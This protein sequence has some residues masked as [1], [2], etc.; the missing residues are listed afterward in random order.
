MAQS[1]PEIIEDANEIVREVDAPSQQLTCLLDAH[2]ADGDRELAPAAEGLVG[3]CE[4][5]SRDDE[6]RVGWKRCDDVADDVGIPHVIDRDQAALAPD[7]LTEI[8]SR[9]ADGS[10]KCIEQ[11]YGSRLLA[12]LELDDPAGVR[13]PHARVPQHLVEKDALAHPARPGHSDKS[14][15][16]PRG[17]PIHQAV[18]QIRSAEDIVADW[19]AV[20]TARARGHHVD[21]QGGQHVTYGQCVEH[22]RR[23]TGWGLRHPRPQS[24]L[25]HQDTGDCKPERVQD[26]A[27]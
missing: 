21:A 8:G 11:V 1:R 12:R 6:R 3:Q 13:R 5:A 19:R 4:P 15:S 20:E 2:R 10:S 9:A 7:G 23:E 25:L 16:V 14:G 24:L 27:S 26:S 17:Q 18:D 22:I